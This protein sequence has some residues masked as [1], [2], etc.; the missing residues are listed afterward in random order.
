MMSLLTTIFVNFVLPIVLI[1]L[2]W[3]LPLMLVLEFGAKK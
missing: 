2:V 3:V 1:F